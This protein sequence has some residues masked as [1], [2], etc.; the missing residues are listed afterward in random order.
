[1][2]VFSG[3]DSKNIQPQ[4]DLEIIHSCILLNLENNLC[5]NWFLAKFI[6]SGNF[7]E[8]FTYLCFVEGRHTEKHRQM[9]KNGR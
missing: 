9:A 8:I 6:S 7:W 2:I 5:Q 3:L 1:M 4:N